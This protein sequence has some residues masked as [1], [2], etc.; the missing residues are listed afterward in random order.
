MKILLLVTMFVFA[1]FTAHKEAHAELWQK[2][3]GELLQ[4]Y[5]TKSGVKYASWHKNKQDLQS[6]R[7]VVA[8]ISQQ[9]LAGMSKVDTLAFY[10]NAYNALIL[11][12]ILKDY[13]TK[14][15][16]GGGFWGRRK[17]FKKRTITVAKKKTNFHS[18][19]NNV[20]RKKFKEPRIHFALNCASASCPPLHTEPFVGSTLDGVLDLLTKNF[21]NRNPKGVSIRGNT[22][23]VSK[24][25]DWY[26]D[27]F[28]PNIAYY[29]NKYRVSKLPK[30]A[31]I[32][33]QDYNWSLNAAR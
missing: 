15:P 5:V 11:H 30:G 33:F 20:I 22:V 19:E 16:G 18:L 21:I 25:F 6:L 28:A 32:K 8:S 14:G 2:N 26:E 17:F 9:K 23:K 7:L 29:V 3:Y 24:I 13:P 31:A 1:G 10:L 12:E 27:D 4:K